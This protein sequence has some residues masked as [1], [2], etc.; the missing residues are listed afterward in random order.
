MFKPLG[1]AVLASLA[2]VGATPPVSGDAGNATSFTPDQRAAILTGAEKALGNYTFT[3][4]VAALR[5]AIE[6][7]RNGYLQID[8]PQAFAKAISADLYAIAH[9][10]H[11]RLVYSAD[12]MPP[13]NDR[14][15]PAE[16]AHM[17]QEQ[18]FSNYGYAGALR[19]RGNVG[20]LKLNG[21]A[22]MPD[23]QA[24]I[25]AAMALLEGTDALIIDVRHNR[26]GDPD[27]LDYLMGY[28]YAKPTELT[29]IVMTHEGQTQT[30][31]QFS[32]AHVRGHRY[33]NKP[34]Y[35]LTD[36]RTFSCAEQFAYDMKSLHRATLIGKTTG[37]AA[38]PGGFFRLDDH[39]A[40]F[41]PLGRAVNPYTQTNWEGTGVVPDIDVASNAALLDAYQRA[42]GASKDSFD[43][44]VVEREAAQKDPAAALAASLPQI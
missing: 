35:V 29:S 4:E 14:P 6:T 25:D 31:K 10:K 8:D 44:A 26:G 40:I 18:R 37:G 24:S 30:I 41:V 1:L 34:L 17:M 28:F 38:N 39:F 3:N 2:L 7:H 12:V 20:Y 36:D 23:A 16:I 32:E 42:L 19:L 11:I 15:S 22:S 9:D 43:E 27:S 5:S 21:F 13:N 33:L